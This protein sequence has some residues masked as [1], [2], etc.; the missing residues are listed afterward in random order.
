MRNFR[1][2]KTKVKLLCIWNKGS[3]RKKENLVPTVQNF[4]NIA[5]L[6]YKY[7]ESGISTET[8]RVAWDGNKETEL[9]GD[10]S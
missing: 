4:T 2:R 6:E 1:P 9:K 5:I 8:G 10:V 3:Y 7:N